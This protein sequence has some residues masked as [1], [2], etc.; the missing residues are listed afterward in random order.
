MG[1]PKPVFTSIRTKAV[2]NLQRLVNG[3]S[4]MLQ[5]IEKQMKMKDYYFHFLFA[6]TLYMESK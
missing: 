2:Y 5:S 3:G 1:V 6:S 4:D